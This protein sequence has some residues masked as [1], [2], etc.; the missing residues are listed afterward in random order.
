MLQALLADRFNLKMH[1]EKKQMP[2]YA[3]EVAKKGPK[4]NKSGPVGTKQVPGD[5]VVEDRA[6]LFRPSV[7][8]NGERMIELTVKS[9]FVQGVADT[10]S[11]VLM[12][13]V[14]NRT[15][16]KGGN[17]FHVGVCSRWRSARFGADWS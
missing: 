7:Q 8:P 13:P 11:S 2:V 14:L 6:F 4:I 10:F 5:A 9:W 15:G 16:L 17:R 1:R 3:L 12:R